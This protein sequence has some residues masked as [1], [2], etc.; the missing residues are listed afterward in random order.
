MKVLKLVLLVLLFASSASAEYRGFSSFAALNSRFPCDKFLRIS[1]AI[2]KPSMVVLFETFGD[3]WSCVKRFTEKFHD[4]DHVLQIHFSNET[5]RSPTRICG[6]GELFRSKSWAD[7]NLL[8]T[9]PSSSTRK[10]LVQRVDKLHLRVSTVAGRKTQVVVTTGLED[11]YGR[12]ARKFMFNFLEKSF[13][14]FVITTNP[15]GSSYANALDTYLELHGVRPDFGPYQPEFCIYNPDG[16]ELTVQQARDARTRY[17]NCFINYLWTE[18]AQGIRPDGRFVD[19]LRR[20][21]RILNWEVAK[22]R[23]LLGE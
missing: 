21:F 3:D 12:E 10:K 1:S 20:R 17:G 4:K 11:R 18:R 5:C 19:P 22:Y 14:Q 7:V 13:P 15:V 2:P 6:K 23:E 8:L 9:R 16:D